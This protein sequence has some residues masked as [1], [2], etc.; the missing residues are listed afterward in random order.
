MN[1]N[2]HFGNDILDKKFYWKS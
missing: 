2:L 1:K